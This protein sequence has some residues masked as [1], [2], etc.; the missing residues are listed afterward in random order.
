[1]NMQFSAVFG[2]LLNDIYNLKKSLRFFLAFFI[3]YGGAVFLVG[4]SSQ[5]SSAITMLTSVMSV[6]LPLSAFSYNQ[7][8]QWEHYALTLPISR[9]QLVISRYLSSFFCSVLIS[10]FSLL[11]V[12]ISGVMGYG[13]WE[14][15]ALSLLIVTGV[16]LFLHSIFNAAIYRF[17]S[18]RGRIIAFAVCAVPPLFA[19]VMVKLMPEQVRSSIISSVSFQKMYALLSSESAVFLLGIFA[20]LLGVFCLS[21][22]CVLTCRYMERKEF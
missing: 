11:V 16:I 13:E 15:T 17:G 4:G 8:S 10:F 1:M 21:V 6:T 12:L 9:R 14:T 18:E 19:A 3:V 2:L 20:L 7:T 22:S 5:Q